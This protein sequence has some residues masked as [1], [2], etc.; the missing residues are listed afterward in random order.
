MNRLGDV[1]HFAAH[2]DCQRSFGD[3]FASTCAD[4]ADPKNARKPANILDQ[5]LE[6]KIK[7]W[8]ADNVLVEQPFVKDDSKTVGDLLKGAGLK[9]VKF[10][11]YRVGDLS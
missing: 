3:Q 8:F 7:T 6:G 4:D 10:I 5:I 2:L 11:R 1:G 9:L